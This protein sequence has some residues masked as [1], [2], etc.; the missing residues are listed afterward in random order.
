MRVGDEVLRVVGVVGSVE[1]LGF[2]R[3][4]NGV[5]GPAD[6]YRPLTRDN[7]DIYGYILARAPAESIRPLVASADPNLAVQVFRLGD[8]LA[9]TAANPRFTATLTAGF[10]GLALVLA[11]IGVAGLVAFEVAQRTQEIGIR[12][13]LGAQRVQVIRLVMSRGTRLVTT[14][15]VIGV[16]A[17]VNIPRQSRGL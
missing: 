17:S 12:T 15:I 1:E 14:G 16:A 3:F 8:D 7:T 9:S 6:L 10:A 2:W 4:I 13:A 11:G 5:D